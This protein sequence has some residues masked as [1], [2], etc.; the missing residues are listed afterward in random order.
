[1]AVPVLDPAAVNVVPHPLVVVV[2]PE[3]AIANVGSTNEIVLEETK[4]TFNANV[5]EIADEA[6]MTGFVI[7]KTLCCNT[8]D[9]GAVVSVDVEIET[10]VMSAVSA[11]VTATVRALSA[12]VDVELCSLALVVT[13]VATVTSHLVPATSVDVLVAAVS[14]RVA[15]V[16]P[17]PDDVAAAN[18]VVPH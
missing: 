1:M 11:N 2:S 9:V 15:V 18:V 10:A 7:I 6:A 16:V 5:K 12:G 4:G 8:D 14:V 3:E 17:D 13:P